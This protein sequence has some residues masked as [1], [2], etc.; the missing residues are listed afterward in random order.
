MIRKL[1]GDQ[2]NACGLTISLLTKTDGT[3]FGKTEGGAIYL[4][5]N[6]T[7]PFAMYQFLLN[8]TDADVGKML[9]F[10]TML[11]EKQI[12]DVMDEHIHEP[13]KRIAQMK[14]T[15]IIVT[16]IHGEVE[17]QRCLKISNTLFKG[18]VENLS[19][20]EIKDALSSLPSFKATESAYNIVDLLVSCKACPSKSEARKLVEANA[21]YVNN[22]LI[23]SIDTIIKKSDALHRNFTYI[24]KGKK[25]Y[26]L[27]Q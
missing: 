12:K 14:L 11:S 16:D 24:K 27:V 25:N 21:I 10:L 8:Q 26:F 17:Y 1:Y 15:Q 19:L 9:K 18:N 20:D 5:K 23:K 6:R 3:K 22:Q 7:T 4:D 13:S 2:N